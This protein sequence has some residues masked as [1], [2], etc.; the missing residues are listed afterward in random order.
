LMVLAFWGINSY[1]NEF[2]IGFIK[3]AVFFWISKVYLV[4]V[5]FILIPETNAI[6]TK[7]RA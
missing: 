4:G 2:P 3:I 7:I 1:F 6:R 5:R